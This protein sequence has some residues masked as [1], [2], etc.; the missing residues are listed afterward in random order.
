MLPF[1]GPFDIPI[2][3]V[4]TISEDNT[5]PS[6]SLRSAIECCTILKTCG[7]LKGQNGWRIQTNDEIQVV[8]R[9]P[10]IVPTVTVRRPELAGHLVRCLM[11]GP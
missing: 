7:S 2:R 10:N 1:K 5:H 11:K 6:L 3:S 8:S 9:K 4:V